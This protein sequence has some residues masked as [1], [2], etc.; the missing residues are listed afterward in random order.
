[1]KNKLKNVKKI[2]LENKMN[3]VIGIISLIAFIV[4]GFAIGW[5][6]A[7]LIIGA[8]DLLLFIPTLIKKKK[9][10]KRVRTK[11]SKAKKKKIF[12]IILIILFSVGILVLAAVFIFFWMIVKNAPDFDPNRLYQKEATIIYDSKGEIIAKLGAEKREKI[13]YEELPEVLVDAII[14]TEDARFFQHNGFD[15]PR[16][17]KASFGQ[18]LGHSDAGGASTITMQ[19]VKNHFTST[20]SKGVEGITRKFTDIYMAIFKVEKKYTKKEI[21]EFYVNSNYLG[22]MISGG[23]YGVEQACLTYFG[24]SAKDIN[25]AEAAM[26]AGL[27]QAPN[28]YDPY[29]NPDLTEK[30]RQTVLYLMERHGYISKEEREIASNMEVTELLASTDNQANKY[31]GFID[32][33]TAEVER[34][35]GNNPYTIPMEIYTTMDKEKQDH[36]YNIT[37]G[38]GFSWENDV[39]NAGISVLDINTGAIVAIGAGRN[40]T[41]ERGFNN[42]TMIKRQIG[43]TAKPLFEYGPGIEYNNWSTYTPFV[44]EEHTYSTNIKLD[45]WDGKYQGLMSLRDALKYSRNI[46]ALKAFQS[47]S[48]KNIRNFVTSL[49]LSPEIEN[50]LIHEAHSIGGYNGESP[51]S[52]S[53]AY[54]AF[55]NGGYYIKP[56]SFTKVVYRDSGESYEQKPKKEKVMSPSTAYMMNDILVDTAKYALGSYSNINGVTYGAKTG[57][58]NFAEA[59]FKQFNLPKGAIN[60]LWVA[61]YNPEYS[62]AVWYGYDKINRDYVTKFGNN[63]HSKLFQAVAKGIF[64]GNKKFDKPNDVIEVEIEKESYPAMLA[65]PYTPKD[66]IVK[67]IFKKGTEP[68][69]V[70][71]RYNQLSNVSNLNSSLNGN[72][73]SLTWD[74]IETPASIDKNKLEQ[75]FKNLYKKE[76]DQTKYLAL[77]LD[78]NNKNIGDLGYNVY[79][80]KADGNLHLLGFTQDNH[81]T[82]T[83]TSTANPITFVVKS[84]YSIFKDNQSKG[85]ELSIEFDGNEDIITSYLNGNSTVTLEVNHSYIEPSP[86]VIVLNNLVDVTTQANI[87]KTIKRVSDNET[88]SSIDTSSAGSYTITYQVSYQNYNETYI[89]TVNIT[90]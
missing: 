53:A 32:T 56:Y 40:R 41:G 33:V 8:I 57:T 59:T 45:N 5:L 69:E 28:S 64:T 50:G 12:K 24:K 47:L 16:F 71:P 1:M 66:M 73:L 54:A 75:Y 34:L 14:A 49:G 42:A 11:A 89:R 70:S 18:L 83:I 60:D 63:Q 25:L 17:A 81:Y 87:T 36:I 86:S 43:S 19:I 27:F 38:D 44:D 76:A 10:K 39:V 74:V 26:I 72:K 23:A 58:T 37:N 79:I 6:T 85:T 2:I 55:A 62:I 80:K 51:L 61:G 30:R 35:T 52:V 48:N 9:K 68:T 3:V 84:A 88:V 7:F 13:T 46:P 22:G 65:S 4:G 77:R 15:L 78:Y 29:I 21:L 82:Y 20:T 90:D 31:Q 67:E